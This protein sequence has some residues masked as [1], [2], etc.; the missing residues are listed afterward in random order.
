[1]KEKVLVSQNPFHSL[2][3]SRAL[4]LTNSS[5][6]GLTSEAANQRLKIFGANTLVQKRKLTKTRI[7]LRQ[8]T[9]P[10]IF[11][12]LIAGGITLIL[13]HYTDALFV[14]S[15]ALANA[16]LGYY[17]ENK[18][19]EALEHLKTYIKQRIRVY[20][21]NLR[22]EIDATN[23]VPGD[24]IYISQGDR[25]PADARIITT[26]DLQVDEAVLTGESLPVTKSNKP[27]KE[28]SPL[29]ER[30]CMLHSGTVAVQ[31]FATALV[32]KTG[33]DT[34]IG[35]IAQLVKE[36]K[37]QLTPLQASLKN[38]TLRAAVFLITL[39][40]GVFFIAITSGMPLLE[41]F[42]L[43][44]VI[45]VSAVPEGLPI[46]MTVILAIGVQRLVKKNA[47]VRKL[48]AAETLGSTTVILT[49]KT[50]TLTQAKME[51]SSITNYYEPAHLKEQ[52]HKH[53]FMLQIA[54]LN[55]DTV[56]ENPDDPVDSWRVT[57]KPVEVA[58][59]IALGNATIPE[60]ENEAYLP[61]N[62]VNKYSA[63]IN[64]ISEKFLTG[65]GTK[66][67]RVLTILGAPEIILNFSR[68]SDE[69]KKE[70]MEEI[71]K[72]AHQG[73]R[74]VGIGL[75]EVH[76][77]ANVNLKDPEVYKGLEFLGTVSLRDPV[78]PGTKEALDRVQKAGVRVVIITGDHAG[79]A[80]AVARELGLHITKENLL[81]GSEIE[82]LTN[83]QLQN[84]LPKIKIISRVSPEGKLKVA[85]AFQ[86]IGAVIAMNGDGVNDAP[87]IKRADIGIA[88]GSGTDVS[89]DVADLVLL[90]N[91]FQ[92][93]VYA[94]EE[95][96]RI[97]NNIRKAIT[98]LA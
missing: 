55:I 43:S 21:D 34:E 24:I 63:S 97:S 40:I 39:T 77:N 95:G 19:E 64:Q 45:L 15:A 83:K 9:N 42:L 44:V 54:N 76:E 49:D 6:S 28:V 86:D 67:K 91:N 90:D 26:N 5:T 85:Q 13:E 79:T 59:R 65:S 72:A 87:A 81:T 3:V 25:I 47:I 37:Q 41:A 73:D 98:Y 16:G 14:I 50:G 1:M 70:I 56:V 27:V 66:H 31:G 23:L 93:I 30:L 75:K 22:I 32:V 8:F 92:T 94:I 61:F 53:T 62:S 69:R 33:D 57:G 7:F 11:I 12:L 96:R 58:V 78:R 38:F 35:K 18:A 2:E 4:E 60:V 82:K 52:E 89:K 74:L 17:Q 88:M 29:A 20:R 68:L 10:L 48:A 71:S 46:V 51:L 84:I 36:G 80:T